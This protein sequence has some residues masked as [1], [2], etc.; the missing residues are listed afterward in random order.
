MH[1]LK[2]FKKFFD[3]ATAA[4]GTF[5][6]RW[7][8][9]GADRDFL[10]RYQG[11]V[12]ACVS[13]I[14]EDVAMIQFKVYS[15]QPDGSLKDVANHPLLTVLDNPNPLMSKY[16]L[17]ELTS[18]H[19]ELCGEAFWY[20]EI[21]QDTQRPKSFYLLPPDRMQVAID[22]T[23]E[24]PTVA[25]YIFTKYNGT[26]VPFDP[27]EITHFKMPNP[28]DPYRGYGTVEAALV[29]IQ[30]EKFSSEYTRNYIFNNAMPAGIVSLKGSVGATEFE[31]VKKQW[32]QEY[33]TI[34]KAGKTAFIQGADITFTQ[35]GTSLGDSA[36]KEIKDMSR[37]DI[38]TMFRVSKPILGIFEDVNLASAKTAQYVFMSRVIDP[39]MMRMVDTLQFVLNRWNIGTQVLVM[40]YV[41]PVPEDVDDKIK[42][43]QAGE[44]Q[45]LTINE[46]RKQEGLEP[47]DGGNVIR[48]PLNLIPIGNEPAPAQVATG[49]TIIRRTVRHT[50]VSA[51]PVPKKKDLNSREYQAKENFRLELMKNQEAWEKKWH[52][53]LVKLVKDQQKKVL[54]NLKEHEIKAFDEYKFDLDAA[55]KTFMDALIPIASE[56]YTQ[57]GQLAMAQILGEQNTETHNQLEFQMTQTITNE[58]SSRVKRMAVNYNQ[59]TLDGITSSLTEGFAANESK[60]DIT[61]RIDDVFGEAKGY[62]SERVARTETLD[63]SNA[64]TKQ[65][66]A[67]TGYVTKIEWFA[68]PDCCPICDELDGSVIGIEND[69]FAPLGTTLEGSDGSTQEVNYTSIDY[70]PAHPNCRCTV[71]PVDE[72]P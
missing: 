18:T 19:I 46:I 34:D 55:V 24:L 6:N 48:Q 39:K 31:A 9:P 15:K 1:P 65:G 29:Y 32:K 37:D 8:N 25:G 35:I 11:Y 14:A 45:W 3:T 56:L 69:T 62:R 26:R 10:H 64:A 43:Y 36:L 58:I 5:F 2:T 57:Q 44:N 60:A 53:T 50:T 33:G 71:L 13:A 27:E 12:Y 52:T 23:T 59:A 41:S 42:I 70:P 61:S 51:T 54:D 30:T 47:V 7:T 16:Q 28:W 38:M 20:S 17:I 63:A 22:T 40:G 21:G 66:Y 4:T 72:S 49:K 67:Q 68:N